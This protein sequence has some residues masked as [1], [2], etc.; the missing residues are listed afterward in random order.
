MPDLD[1]RFARGEFGTLRDWL[2]E[3]VHRHGRRL[4]PAELVARAT[5]G[6]LDPEPYL[7]YVRAKL[8]GASAGLIA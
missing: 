4:L 8:A 6:P 5:G 7:D 1:E 2:R 3:H